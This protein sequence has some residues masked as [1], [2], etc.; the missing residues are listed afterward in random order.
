MGE[1]R[2]IYEL[3]EIF[4]QTTIETLVSV[5]MDT[6]IEPA[7]TY[8]S[9][10]NTIRVNG[11]KLTAEMIGEWQISVTVYKYP[12]YNENVWFTNSFTLSILAPKPE[13]KP[14]PQPQ[15]SA[16]EDILKPNFT[17]M[18]VLET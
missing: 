15:I 10:F 13:S 18:V 3:G 12:Q 5:E 11:Y 1:M 17:G 14:K 16:I 7:V 8:D 9:L 4:E 6:M 2:L